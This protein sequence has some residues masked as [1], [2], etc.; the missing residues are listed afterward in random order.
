MPQYEIHVLCSECGAEHPMRVRLHLD[1]GPVEKRSIGETY[2]GR[3][4][5]PQLLAIGGH[6]TLCL[7]TGKMFVQ[8]N[9]DQ[10]FLIPR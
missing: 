8:E 9:D 3:T 10:I 4:Q 1:D 6:K 2:K 5:P 7:K